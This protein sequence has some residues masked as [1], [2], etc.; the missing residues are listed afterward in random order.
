MFH[1]EYGKECEFYISKADGSEK[2]IY[3]RIRADG[4]GL[5]IMNDLLAY[6][7]KYK[8][9]SDR[10]I[11]FDKIYGKWGTDGLKQIE[12]LYGIKISLSYI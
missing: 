3:K 8:Y 12:N 1:E 7:L 2:E 4:L 6:L 11:V 10:C 5:F 9:E